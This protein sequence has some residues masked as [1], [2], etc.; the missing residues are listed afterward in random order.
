MGGVEHGMGSA[1]H[2]VDR[3]VAEVVAVTEVD[4]AGPP[5]RGQAEAQ[6]AHVISPRRCA[7]C[8]ASARLRTDSLRYS[9]D[10]CSLTVCGER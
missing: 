4:V 8:T 3:A 6:D 9:D 1:L 2:P 5:E 10:V 7:F